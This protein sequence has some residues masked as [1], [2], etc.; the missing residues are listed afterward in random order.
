MTRLYLLGIALLCLLPV[1]CNS[2]A[3][4]TPTVEDGID[5][6]GWAALTEQPFEVTEAVF[7][8]CR[9]PP[10]DREQRGPHFVPAVRV[11]ANP[12]ALAAVRAGAPA[13]MPVGSA[14][15]KEKWWNKQ[16]VRPDAYAAMI[17]REPGYDTENGD[18]EYVYVS[19][20]AEEKVQRGR[21]ERCIGC[22]RTAAKQ[23]YLFRTYLNPAGEK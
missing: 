5:Y 6:A 12:T 7:T 23:D 15:V 18:W 13:T 19:F 1:A 3:G 22:H 20:D 21:I 4:R 17:K 8:Y 2:S 11:Y 14:V 9:E 10:A 16:A